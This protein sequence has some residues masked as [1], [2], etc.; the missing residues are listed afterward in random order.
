MWPPFRQI[1]VMFFLGWLLA[2]LLD[3]IASWL[4]ARVPRLPRGVAAA[5]TFL[6]V[7]VL[8]VCFVGFVALSFADSLTQILSGGPSVSQ[9]VSQAIASVQSLADSLGIA[10]DVHGLVD[11]AVESA[12][13]QADD[14]LSGALGG[15][16]NALTMGM[17]I[18]FVA[19]VIVAS[20]ANF[21]TFTRRLVPPDQLPLFDALSRSIGHSFGGFMRGQFGLA[22]LYGLFVA[23]VAIVLGIPFV[24]FIG[25]TTAL[26]QT[27]PFFGQLVSWIP[28]VLVTVVFQPDDLLA[29][30]VIML[31][32]WV[33]IQNI[34]YP[35]V[36]GT[37]VGLNPLVVLAAVF[38]GGALAGPL[39]A[40]FGV[41]VV[42]AVASVFMVWLDHVRPERDLPPPRKRPVR[43]KTRR[44]KPSPA[45]ATPAGRP[46]G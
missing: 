40:V 6:V 31:V 44:P 39:G 29:V 11:E 8:L 46:P 24:P 19:V 35:R 2:F 27:I 4:V 12:R 3:P 22:A 15:A 33:V 9:A 42:A 30:G 18:A 13:G 28:L 23:L 16:L 25:V 37:A 41:P 34:V 38:V 26:L 17:T 21:L 10:V 5:V 43:R 7:T 36:M 32:G 1:A 45:P 20:K 14:I